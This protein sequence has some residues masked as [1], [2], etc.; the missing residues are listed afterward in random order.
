MRD[1][2]RKMELSP[3]AVDRG[4]VERE[5]ERMGLQETY[6]QMV[7]E[8]GRQRQQFQIF[9]C[10]FLMGGKGC[11]GSGEIGDGKIS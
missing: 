7:E 4:V 2:R 9:D 3:Q 11:F 6:R 8:K 5:L 1:I 10:G